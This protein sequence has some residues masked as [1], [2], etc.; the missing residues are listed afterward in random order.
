MNDIKN[1]KFKKLIRAIIIWPRTG[2]NPH[3]FPLYKIIWRT[4]WV[5]LSAFTLLVA[6]ILVCFFTLMIEP[7]QVGSSWRRITRC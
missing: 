5:L 4:P 3:N 1:S 6:A 2:R 7:S